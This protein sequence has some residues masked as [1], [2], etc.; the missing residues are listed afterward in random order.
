MSQ[1]GFGLIPKLGRKSQVRLEAIKGT[2]PMPLDPP[3]QCGFWSR[4][5]ERIAGRCNKAVPALEECAGGAAGHRVRCF[6][7][8][9][10]EEP[11]QAE[12]LAKGRRQRGHRGPAVPVAPI[13]GAGGGEA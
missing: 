11:R 2:V 8:A 4:C 12:A 13:E 1:L 3:W 5:P 7:R 6:L 10:A 9:D